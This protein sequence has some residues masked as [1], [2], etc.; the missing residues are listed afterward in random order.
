MYSDGVS[1][2]DGHDPYWSH[3][4]INLLPAHFSM[5]TR[6]IRQKRDDGKKVVV[7]LSYQGITDLSKLAL[8]KDYDLRQ[9]PFYRGNLQTSTGQSFSQISR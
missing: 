8:P 2:Q 7:V 9:H 5:I 4:C 3:G 1:V 6:F